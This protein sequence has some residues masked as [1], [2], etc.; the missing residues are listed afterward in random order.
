MTTLSLADAEIWAAGAIEHAGVKTASARSVA[1]ALVGAEA[2]GLTGHGLGRLPTYVA[3]VEHG[4]IDGRS[5]PTLT[6]TRPGAAVIDAAH[7]FAY[8]AIDPANGQDAIDCSAWAS[9]LA[10]SGA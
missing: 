6:R 4:K 1:A 5:V 8:P 3:M 10:R 9:G 2:D 7:G